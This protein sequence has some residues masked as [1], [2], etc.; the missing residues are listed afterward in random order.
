MILE[1]KARQH[2]PLINKKIF[3]VRFG[4]FL[5]VSNN[6]EFFKIFQK[7]FLVLPLLSE[8]NDPKMAIL[9]VFGSFFSLSLEIFGS[10]RVHVGELYFL[11]SPKSDGEFWGF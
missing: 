8:R 11:K 1:N 7:N 10:L 4:P 9:T 3:W 5:G 6:K 2:G